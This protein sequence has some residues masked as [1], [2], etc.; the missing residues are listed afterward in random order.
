VITGVSEL[1]GDQLFPGGM[2][3]ES[4]GTGSALDADGNRKDHIF[5]VLKPINK[6][7]ESVLEIFIYKAK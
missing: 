7:L 6:I 5:H 1:L 3:M 2:G 4:C